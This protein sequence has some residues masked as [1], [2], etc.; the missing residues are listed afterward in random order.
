[1]RGSWSR[2]LVV[3]ALAGGLMI[4]GFGLGSAPTHAGDGAVVVPTPTTYDP[5]VSFAPLVQAVLPA[6]VSIRVEGKAEV[7]ERLPPEVERFFHLDPRMM[8]PG[9]QKMRGE[10]SGFVVSADGLVLTNHHVIAHADD[11]VAVFADGTEA[12]ATIVGS[13]ES[14]DVAL[15]RLEGKRA[16]PFVE[17]GAA[18]D[19]KVGDWVVA[20]GN[21]L[22]LGHTVTAGIISGKGRTIGHDVYDDFLQTDAAI[23]SGNS[24]GPLFDLNGRVVGI[25]TAIVGG[26]N[27]VGFAIPSELVKGAMSDLLTTGH[28][29]R[30][31][32]GVMSQ[33]MD[34]ALEKSMGAKGALVAEVVAG[35]PAA[36]AGLSAGDVVTKVGGATVGNPEELTRAIGTKKP[37]EK[38]DVTYVRDGKEKTVAIVLGERPSNDALR[39]GA[40]PAP[41][42]APEPAPAAEKTLGIE[43][44][45][46]ESMAAK[47]LGVDHGVLVAAVSREGSAARYL[48]PGDVIVEVNKKAVQTPADV[49]AAIA[50][51]GDTVLFLIERGNGQT[52]VAVPLKG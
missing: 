35:A 23:N 31:Y 32:V 10:G 43:L 34:P 6:V 2:P 50:R 26:A 36:K 14:L 52:F 47:A 28:V 20:V 46:V 17:L 15:L 37:G 1:M 7:A 9:D 4:A 25:N 48:R 5:K 21:P 22:G 11:I 27:T 13:D 49:E 29:A 42:A 8:P 39:G 33:P 45:S 41:E 24:G 38:V 18:K 40:K 19:T 3:G 51:S 44:R 16:W 12:K 30:G